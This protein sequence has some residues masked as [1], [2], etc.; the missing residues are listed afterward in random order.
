M[1]TLKI[2]MAI[3][4]V[5]V[6]GIVGYSIAQEFTSGKPLIVDGHTIIIDDEI[7]ELDGIHTPGRDQACRRNNVE[8]PCG[9]LSAA[10]L[11]SIVGE[12]SL[13]CI[14]RLSISEKRMVATCYMG[15]KDVGEAQVMEGWAEYEK[16]NTPKYVREEET[17]R[18]RGLG[19]WRTQP[20]TAG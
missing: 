9:M 3:L 19:M 5:T 6:L 4:F 17:A 20:I 12:Q 18:R 1:L 2:I 11:L 16:R 15:I 14:E 13:W 8:W 10:S 7:I